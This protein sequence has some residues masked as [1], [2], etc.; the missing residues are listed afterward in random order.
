MQFPIVS[1]DHRPHGNFNRAFHCALWSAAACCRLCSCGVAPAPER[2]K[3]ACA[4]QKGRAKNVAKIL[5][6]LRRTF[7]LVVQRHQVSPCVSVVNKALEFFRNRNLPNLI[8]NS[9]ISCSLA[10]RNRRFDELTVP[11]HIGYSRF[12]RELWTNAP[13]YQSVKLPRTVVSHRRDPGQ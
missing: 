3:Q 5:A 12:A 1:H 2:R 4:L 8:D 11:G 10:F 13:Q 9:P 6:R 7:G